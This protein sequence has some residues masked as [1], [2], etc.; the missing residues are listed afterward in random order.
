MIA[1]AK[2]FVFFLSQKI[3][4]VAELAV[5]KYTYDPDIEVSMKLWK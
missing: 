1:F 4:D 2:R 3:R 5:M